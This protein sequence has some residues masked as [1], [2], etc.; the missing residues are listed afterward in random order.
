MRVTIKVKGHRVR[1]N[2]LH[3]QDADGE[4]R[5]LKGVLDRETEDVVKQIETFGLVDMGV[6][7]KNRILAQLIPMTDEIELEL[8]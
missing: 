8:V 6:I 7:V 2:D 4:H 1:G 5:I 3:F